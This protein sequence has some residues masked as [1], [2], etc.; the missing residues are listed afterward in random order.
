[1]KIES[2]RR[3]FELVNDLLGMKEEGDEGGMAE[4]RSGRTGEMEVSLKG[5]NLHNHGYNPWI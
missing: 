5:L 1:L 3:K 4:C 2:G